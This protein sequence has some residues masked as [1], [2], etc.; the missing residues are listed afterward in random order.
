MKVVTSNHGGVS[1]THVENIL[2]VYSLMIEIALI[3]KR[4]NHCDVPRA[5][6]SSVKLIISIFSLFS[7]LIVHS[8]ILE[9]HD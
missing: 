7:V 5:I 2:I 3:I 4:I 6:K 8:R 9:S 1:K